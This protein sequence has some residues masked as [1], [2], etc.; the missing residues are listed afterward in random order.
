M[1]SRMWR[2]VGFIIN[3]RFGGSYL[4]HLQ[5]NNIASE[6]NCWT[7]SNRLSV[8]EIRY[9]KGGGSG[10][11]RQLTAGRRSSLTAGA[12]VGMAA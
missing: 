6:E 12:P 4:F 11:K 10:F 8:H 7:V 3:L 1:S 5:D 2:R 9:R